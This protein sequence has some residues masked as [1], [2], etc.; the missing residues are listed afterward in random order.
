MQKTL[1]EIAQYLSGQVQGDSQAVITGISGIKE[2]KPGDITFVANAKYF[3]LIA[4]TQASAILAPPGT[5]RPQGKN[6]VLVENPSLA[7][8]R[9][10][11]FV[12]GE[13]VHEVKGIHPT[14]VIAK[15]AKIGRDVCIG[16]HTV[17]ESE[18]VIGEGTVIYSGSIS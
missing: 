11:A 5:Q 6:F 2:A 10:A 12:L 13:Q 15:S 18:A 8:A 7:F 17:I 16:A 3:P 4:S 1:T 14:A 9:I